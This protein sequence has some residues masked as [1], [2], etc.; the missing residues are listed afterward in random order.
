MDYGLIE[1]S[2]LLGKH[3]SGG[4]TTDVLY[5][6]NVC[7]ENFVVSLKL[8]ELFRIVSAPRAI[9]HYYSIATFTI[10]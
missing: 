4:S 3:A 5:H 10:Y 2:K 7:D 1:S 8:L 9:T 6:V